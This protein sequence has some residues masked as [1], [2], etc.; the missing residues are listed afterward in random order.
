MR[1]EMAEGYNDYIKYYRKVGKKI[2]EDKRQ[3]HRLKNLE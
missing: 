2:R 1:R 3:G